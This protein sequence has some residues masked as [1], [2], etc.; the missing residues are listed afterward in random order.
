[1]GD[2]P[3]QG[4][5]FADARDCVVEDD[6]ADREL[7]LC[8]LNVNS[9]SVDRAQHIVNWL[10]DAGS[11]VSVLTE[12]RTGAA[13]QLVRASLEAS[14]YHVS[15]TPGWRDDRY[16]TLVASKGFHVVPV[17]P[18][19]FDPRIVAVDL[20]SKAGT[21]RVVGVYGPTNGMTADSSR[22]RRLFQQRFLK[23]LGDVH[24]PRL[25]VVGDLNVVEPNHQPPLSNF[26]EH[27]F[28]FYRGLLGLGLRDA[29]RE[30]NP[31]GGDHSW[32]SP[33]YGSQ[34]L[35][36]ALVDDAVGSR[37]TCEYDHAPRYGKLSDHAA[38]KVVIDL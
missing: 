16:H 25:C 38:L 26:E 1:M 29:Y 17:E 31:G 30:C 4:M 15:V 32:M 12:L 18:V 28:D 11:N 34:R 37:R 27:D 20:T 21:I 33:R 7:R 22:S 19:A 2:D 36:H 13:T 3:L 9:P 5:L 10:L 35:D 24:R 6:L 8:S 14:A 23:Y